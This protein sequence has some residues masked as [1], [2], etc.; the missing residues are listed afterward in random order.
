MDSNQWNAAANMLV[1][2]VLLLGSFLQMLARAQAFKPEE[3]NGV[4]DSRTRPQK[5]A[6]WLNTAGS[7]VLA[8]GAFVAYFVA[9]GAA[10]LAGNTPNPFIIVVALVSAGVVLFSVV[11]IVMLWLGRLDKQDVSGTKDSKA[12][13]K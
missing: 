4:D 12:A 3:P 10:F 7:V 5:I 9:A 6:E 8:F 1:T 11:M 13:A 2:A